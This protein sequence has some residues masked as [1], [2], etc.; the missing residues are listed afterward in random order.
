MS[1]TLPLQ[2]IGM[3][4]KDWVNCQSWLTYCAPFQLKD[5]SVNYL[6]TYFIF[7]YNIKI[8]FSH[9]PL[10]YF[11]NSALDITSSLIVFVVLPLRTSVM[12]SKEANI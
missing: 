10:K 11:F 6:K 3:S 2:G 12:A 8:F 4:I 1:R 7:S 9:V 5:L